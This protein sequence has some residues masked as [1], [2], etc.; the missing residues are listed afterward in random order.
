[1]R[2]A[3]DAHSLGTNSGGNE[4][5]IRNLIGALSEID[6]ENEY[7]IY[8]NPDAA[9]DLPPNYKIMKIKTRNRWLRPLFLKSLVLKN[10]PDIY[11]SQHFLPPLLGCPS[12]VT[13]HDISFLAHP[14][15]FTG[16]EKFIFKFFNNSIKKAKKIIT[17][18][19]FSKNELLKLEYFNTRKDKI[20]AIYCGVSGIFNPN[21]PGSII[22]KVKLKYSLPDNYILYVG[23][24]NVRKNIPALV[25][26]FS[27]FK[28]QD[29]TGFKLVLVGRR[30]WKSENLT[31]L[32]HKLGLSDEVKFVDYLPYT[33]LPALY[34]AARLFVF[35]S[36]Y[37]GFGLPPLEAMACGIPVITSHTSAFPEV[38]ADAA[39]KIDPY[40]TKKIAEAM[41]KLLSDNALREKM[42]FKGLEQ[43][44]KFNWINTA[45]KTLEVYK[46]A[47]L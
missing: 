41:E 46:E 44:R 23:R 11:H 26:A 17:V 7:V 12:V 2:I 38:L 16:R 9:L 31:E 32:V 13:I 22:Y 33:D 24:F 42:I 8:A 1:M 10:S 3:I 39:M 27:F 37:E 19:A 45:Q 29:K 15:W 5:Y 43:A 18:S 36:F 35:P 14:E 21:I 30:D 6:R 47:L 4:V 28:R 25:R 34:N 20:H 40:D